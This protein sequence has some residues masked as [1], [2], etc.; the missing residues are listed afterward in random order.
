MDISNKALTKAYDHCKRL[1]IEADSNF[2]LSFRFLP[3]PKRDAIYAVYAFNRRADDFADEVE[4]EH[5]RL[6]K[7]EQWEYMLEECYNGRAEHPVMIAFTDAIQKFS[8]PI[9][10]FKDAM[11]GFK[12]DLS[13]NRYKTFD[14]LKVYCDRVAG[15]ISIISL[16]IFGFD[17]ESVF[18]YGNNLSYALQ[19]TNIIRDVGCDIDKDRIYL[20][21]EELERF[22]YSEGELL[23]RTVNDNFR[24]LMRFQID[25]AISY[26]KAA[27]PVIKSVEPDSQYTV[28]MI[29]AVYAGLLRK[30]IRM[31]IPVLNEVVAL[32][33]F[34][35]LGIALRNKVNP[36][37]KV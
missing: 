8:I 31:N 28:T 36:G 4:F 7:L 16:H 14:E 33:K 22:N 30:I 19:L 20:P 5:S 24:E 15:T 10:P 29:G 12:M 9:K 35:K 21:L 27:E 34:E 23:S 18:E 2:A 37:F 1:T 25:R 6:N 11:S 32:T 17:D 26:F 13:I 3:K